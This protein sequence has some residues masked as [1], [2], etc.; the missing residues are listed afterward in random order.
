MKY[1]LHLDKI[2]SAEEARDLAINWQHTY[3]QERVSYAE[4][5]DWQHYFVELAMKFDLTEEF[6]ENGII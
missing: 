4:L 2:E 5:L 3:S 6:S 1:F